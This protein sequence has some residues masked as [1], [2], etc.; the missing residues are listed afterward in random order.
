M[1]PI[2]W[3][4]FYQPKFTGGVN[5]INFVLWNKAAIIKLLWAIAKKKD[6]LWV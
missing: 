1:A 6:Q 3:S 2:A 4:K 5:L